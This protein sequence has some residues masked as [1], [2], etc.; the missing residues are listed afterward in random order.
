MLNNITY[1]TDDNIGQFGQEKKTLFN[2][3][4]ISPGHVVRFL[5]CIYHV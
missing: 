3:V 5:Q 1:N 2:A 4:F